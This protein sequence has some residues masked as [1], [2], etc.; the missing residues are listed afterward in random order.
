MV[1]RY[2]SVNLRWLFYCG[3]LEI[4]INYNISICI[5]NQNKEVLCKDRNNFAFYLAKMKPNQFEKQHFTVIE[6]L[7]LREKISEYKRLAI[8]YC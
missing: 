3:D 5:N 4:V 8:A 1:S 6:Q 7:T 2:T